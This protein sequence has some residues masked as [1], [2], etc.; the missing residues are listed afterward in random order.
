M[1]NNNPLFWFSC[2]V[3]LFPRGDCL[4]RCNARPTRLPSW[5]WAKCLLTRADFNLWRLDVEFVASLYNIFLRREQIQ[6]VEASCRSLHFTEGAKRDLDL[7]VASG[8]VATAL[9]SGDVNSVRDALRKKDLDKPIRAAMQQIQ[10]SL[11][12]VRGSESER[13]NLMP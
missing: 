2:F 4:E 8:L 1:S 6:A 9:A 3:R 12:S 11:R 5:R 13:D 10:I 7:L